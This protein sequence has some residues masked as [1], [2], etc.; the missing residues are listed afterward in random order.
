M[1]V[2]PE[3]PADASRFPLGV[4][5]GSRPRPTYAPTMREQWLTREAYPARNVK[6]ISG[7]HEVRWKVTAWRAVGDPSDEVRLRTVVAATFDALGVTSSFVTVQT[8]NSSRSDMH[9]DEFWMTCDDESQE[10]YEHASAAKE[11]LEATQQRRWLSAGEIVQELDGLYVPKRSLGTRHWAVAMK[12]LLS[13]FV[14]QY[15]RGLPVF[16]LKAEPL[17]VVWRL[18]SLEVQA[19]DERVGTQPREMALARRRRRALQVLYERELGVEPLSGQW[20]GTMLFPE[21]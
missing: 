11:A 17:E 3:V 15:D 18:R 5:Q 7:G 6:K 19:S 4:F 9:I 10:L 12:A 16:I 20:M 1:S 8:R 2:V 14:Q 21:D 13:H